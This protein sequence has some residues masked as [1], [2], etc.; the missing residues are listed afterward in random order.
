VE[1]KSVTIL[2]ATHEQFAR[3]VREALPR[4]RFVPAEVAGRKVRQLVEQRFGFEL[5]HP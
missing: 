2:S 3:S 4:M 5:R 1:R